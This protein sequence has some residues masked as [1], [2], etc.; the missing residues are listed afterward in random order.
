MADGCSRAFLLYLCRVLTSRFDVRPAV[1]RHDNPRAVFRTAMQTSPSPEVYWRWLLYVYKS[2]GWIPKQGRRRSGPGGSSFPFSGARG[3]CHPPAGRN[4][5][6][7]WPQCRCRNQKICQQGLDLLVAGWVWVTGIYRISDDQGQ[8]PEGASRERENSL[9]LALVDLLQSG[10]ECEKQIIF[11][12]I[13]FGSSPS[14]SPLSYCTHHPYCSHNLRSCQR[15]IH[16][17]KRLG[18]SRIPR[19]V[20]SCRFLYPS[21]P[22]Y[23]CCAVVFCP[24]WCQSDSAAFPTLARGPS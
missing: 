16:C 19:L 8:L 15:G 23:C 4:L 20:V 14:F 6:N 21:C 10:L 3:R 1:A 9:D 13:G 18:K 24:S 5:A 7:G 12:D 17:A 22:V 11:C 2:A